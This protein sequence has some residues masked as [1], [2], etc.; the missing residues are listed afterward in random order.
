MRRN[1]SIYIDQHRDSTYRRKIRLN[2]RTLMKASSL[3]AIPLTIALITAVSHRGRRH[4]LLHSRGSLVQT[5]SKMSVTTST[6]S[7]I[8]KEKNKRP[9]TSITF[10]RI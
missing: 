3:A 8:Q 2:K 4:N 9:T 5:R 7:H 6:N 10:A 1:V